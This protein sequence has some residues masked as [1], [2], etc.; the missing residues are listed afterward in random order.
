MSE[1]LEPYG[2]SV[3]DMLVAALPRL[4]AGRLEHAQLLACAGYH[5]VLGLVSLLLDGDGEAALRAVWCAGRT[6]AYG[7]RL[8]LPGEVVVSRAAPLF[9]MVASEDAE[10][11]R[12]VESA[13][14]GPWNSELEYED[15]YLYVRLTAQAALELLRGMPARPTQA[16]ERLIA[17]ALPDD[18]RPLMLRGLY[19]GSGATLEGAL[20]QYLAADEARLRK[21]ADAGYLGE[22]W[23]T[24]LI[25]ASIEGLAWVRLAEHAQ[26]SLP[27]DIARVPPLLRQARVGTLPADSWREVTRRVPTMVPP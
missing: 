15:D 21:R 3:E 6:Y 2:Q 26:L 16:Y 24:T 20:R 13:L 12:E 5:R 11:V 19:E 17:V 10:S 22:E 8:L 27:L 25:P 23:A 7:A 14:G 4:I 9:D 1:F 18:P